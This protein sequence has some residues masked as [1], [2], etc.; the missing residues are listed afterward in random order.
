MGCLSKVLALAL[1]LTVAISSLL[2]VK[3][4]N[5]QTIPL[6]SQAQAVT[7]TIPIEGQ[8]DNIAISPNGACVYVADS[9]GLVVIDTAGN[10]VQTIDGIPP[11]MGKLDD[12]N[13]LFS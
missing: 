7:A 12:W 10:R 4:A 6:P 11:N 13:R 8:P 2:M 3:P 5:A 9:N 1:I